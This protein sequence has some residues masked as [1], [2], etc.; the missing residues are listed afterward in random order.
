MQASEMFGQRT[1]RITLDMFHGARLYIRRVLYSAF[2]GRMLSRRKFLAGAT[3]TTVALAEP[4]ASRASSQ[5]GR[6]IMGAQTHL[7]LAER[8]DRP[9]LSKGTRLPEPYTKERLL[10]IIDEAGVDRVVLIPP[11][12]EGECTGDVSNRWPE[13]TDRAHCRTAPGTYSDYRSHGRLRGVH[14]SP[15][16]LGLER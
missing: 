15:S 11:A 6:L 8:P 4:R 13:C 7:W 9:W 1:Y 16:Q 14:G 10:P 5:W 12:L 2:G 3:T